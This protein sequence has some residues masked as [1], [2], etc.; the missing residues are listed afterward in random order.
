ML[1]ILQVILLD[2]NLNYTQ[3]IHLVSMLVILQVILLDKLVTS[4]VPLIHVSM[5]VILQVILLVG[6]IFS[7]PTDIGFQCLLFCKLFF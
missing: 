6:K 7:L 2:Y 1:V 4:F 5:L 3:L